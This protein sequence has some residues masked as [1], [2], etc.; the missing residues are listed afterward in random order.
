MHRYIGKWGEIVDGALCKGRFNLIGVDHS[1]LPHQLCEESCIVAGARANM[2]DP[3]AFLWSQGCETEG[4]QRRLPIVQRPSATEGNDNILVQNSR[5][6]R[7]RLHISRASE[8]LPRWR[9]DKLLSRSR[10]ERCCKLA[11][12]RDTS[13]GCH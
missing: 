7:Q 1:V 4:V 10:C 5:I 11:A 8:H 13:L 9:P 2:D 12:R 6:I 3:F